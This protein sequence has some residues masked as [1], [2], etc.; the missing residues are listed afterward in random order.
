MIALVLPGMVLA[1]VAGWWAWL[2]RDPRPGSIVPRWRPPEGL[3]PGL[4]GT[5]LDQRA[6]PRD[7]LATILDLARRGYLAIREAHPSGLPADHPETGF[8]R[9]IL[10]RL[11]LWETEWQ[12]VRSERPWEGLE[13]FEKTTLVT[14]FGAD[15][16]HPGRATTMTGLRETFDEGFEAIRRDH[17]RALV[18]RGHF[19]S[20]PEATRRH[21]LLLAGLFG[22][23]AAIAA[24]Q[25]DLPFAT[26]AALSG[27]IV[28]LFAPWMPAVTPAGARAR[29]AA[30]GL[31][32]YLAR[33][34]RAEIERRYED[35]AL[36]DPFDA[37]LPW[38]LALGVADA[39]IG[40]FRDALEAPPAWY[41]Q[42]EGAAVPPADGLAAFCEVSVVVLSG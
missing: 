41:E 17:Y 42:V 21:W 18:A 19:A 40:E 12:F 33:A 7:A 37:L 20:G 29:D 32:E 1:L 28:A 36:P 23:V 11:D 24:T 25:G 14:L 16:A 30:L 27:G 22:L 6:D 38:A 31:E 3:A 35:A 15:V 34:E 2:G 4:A 5:L 26:G 9:E 8:L 13:R 10:E 39:W